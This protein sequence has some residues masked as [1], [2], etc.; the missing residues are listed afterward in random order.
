MKLPQ[1]PDRIQQERGRT[2]RIPVYAPDHLPRW[3]QNQGA[4][5]AVCWLLAA[6][7]WVCWLAV[8]MSGYGAYPDHPV[9]AW[10]L[11]AVGFYLLVS[12][13]RHAWVLH[14]HRV[15]MGVQMATLVDVGAESWDR[16]PPSEQRDTL[17]L[18]KHV[19]AAA[20]RHDVPA[21]RDRV[22][23]LLKL[24]Q[25][26]VLA[27][28]VRTGRFDVDATTATADA[29]QETMQREDDRP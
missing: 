24:E 29:R 19:Y 17:D 5:T 3:E 13:I 26:C 15:G 18:V 8:L 21:V 23:A 12:P 20:N 10:L 28:R 22:E 6:V 4:H 11:F 1:V 16:L 14:N 7:A 9:I 27:E 25:S 2:Y